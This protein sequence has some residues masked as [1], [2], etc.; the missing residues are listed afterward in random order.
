MSDVSSSYTTP[1]GMTG[2]GG[3]NMLRIT[4]MATGLD[5]DA[6]VKKMMNV[7][8]IKLDKAKQAQQLIVWKQ[9]AY[10]DI[11]ASIK[12]LQS[13][14]FDPLN[15]SSNLLSSNTFNSLTTN[16]GDNSIATATAVSGATAG[17]YTVNV[18]KLA[19]GA[20]LTSNNSFNTQFQITDI[21][22]WSGQSITFSVDGG[23][24]QTI[25][26]PATTDNTTTGY[27]SLAS[28]INTAISSNTALNGKVS[29]S[30]V[31][32]SNGVNYIKFTPL[33]SSA[34]QITSTGVSDITTLNTNLSS[35]ST[36]TSL[37]S[38]GASNSVF[39]LN[40]TLNGSTSPIT[41][42]IDN[43]NGTKTIGD[44]ITQINNSTS[45]QVKASFDD[46][47]GK[48]VIKNSTT[49]SS[50]SLQIT[51][52]SGNLASLLG[53]PGTIA[54]GSDAV[55]SIKSPGSANAAVLTESSNSF[56]VN[57]ITY[58]LNS[59]GQT[60]ITVTANTQVVHDRIKTFLDKYNAVIDKIQTKLS[61]KKNYDYPPLTDAQKSSMKDSD[62]TAWNAKAQQGV[63]RNDDNLENLLYNLRNAFVE[64]LEYNGTDTKM[65]SLHFGNTG[66]GAI[67]ID[68]PN[69]LNAA[70]DGDKITIIDD[71]KFT[72]AIENNTSDL[73]KLF[74][75]ISNDNHGNPIYSETGIFQRINNILKD[76][77]GYVG[78]TYNSGI[79]TKYANL[80][81]DYSITGSAGQ[82]TIPDQ[83][84]YQQLMIN[85]IND[86][87]STKQELYYQ[88]F[89]QLETAMNTMNAQ[90]SQLSQ[91][92]G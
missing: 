29:A 92:M 57:N 7:E 63:L 15:P 22:K 26:L 21:A 53:I 78:T 82:N 75:N 35:A 62:I 58:N 36:S 27:S 87:M 65:T 71:A 68:T 1:T 8:Q 77:V 52:S 38:L 47:T 28:A 30:F 9:Q 40:L 14:F 12:D 6:M 49:G 86:A 59:T 61:E 56:T 31:Q 90:Q 37:T 16:S 51:D 60:N 10:Q 50:S 24:A 33:T 13:S 54:N 55:V 67:G 39:T 3:G 4:G 25:N 91:M 73:I 41:V 81:D 66:T 89:S 17:T 11:I 88:Q 44:V 64:P 45:G 23:N 2:A 19:Q 5:V 84:Y 42:T 70:S 32:D 34:V 83:I 46:I 80:Q 76:N 85:K 69:G 20:Q 48:F 74:T 72:A 43:S 18:T 79:L